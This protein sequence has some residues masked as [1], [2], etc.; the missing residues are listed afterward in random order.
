MTGAIFRMLASAMSYILAYAVFAVLLSSLH[1]DACVI[2]MI[3]GIYVICRCWKRERTKNI[4][5]LS[6]S[7][8]R[9]F[10]FLQKELLVLIGLGFFLNCFVGG[11]LNL[12]PIRPEVA[13]SYRNMSSAPVEGVHPFLAFFVISV[14]APVVEEIFFRGILLRRLASEISPF[15]ALILVSLVF[16]LMHGQILWIVYASVLGLVLGMLYL[17]YG[18]IYPSM[19]VHISFN[20]VSGI[21]MLLNP[22]GWLYRMTYG[23]QVFRLLMAAGGLIGVILILFQIYFPKFMKSEGKL[24]I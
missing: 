9:S 5:F 10:P 4:D 21:P 18:S 24:Q 20:L 8:F 12:L 23:S 13:E 19:L 14:A 2:Q 3:S 11:V 15:Y 6:V 7:G 1:T 17:L 22:S 16:G